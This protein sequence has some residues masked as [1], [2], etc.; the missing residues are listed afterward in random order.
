MKLVTVRLYIT[1]RNCRK[2]E[3]YIERHK[4]RGAFICRYLYLVYTL[5][6]LPFRFWTVI[7]FCL[8]L[9]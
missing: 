5:I 8:M 1:C 3:R 4:I 7:F 2:A 6:L 9:L